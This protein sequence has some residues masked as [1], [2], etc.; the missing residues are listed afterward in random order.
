MFYLMTHSTHF[1]LW[2]YGVRHIVKNHS[3]REE[4]HCFHFMGYSFQL[5]ARDFLMHH[6]TDT[7]VHTMTVVTPVVE[8]WLECI[9]KK[10]IAAFKM[11]QNP[12]VLDALN[13]RRK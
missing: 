5:A 4:T 6:S 11:V 7:L 13:I 8:H 10:Y 12:V 9:R 2:L 1:Y 3:G